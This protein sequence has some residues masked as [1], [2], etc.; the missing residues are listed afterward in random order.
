VD[1]PQSG[2]EFAQ[3]SPKFKPVPTRHLAAEQV[4]AFR[5]NAFA[6]YYAAPGYRVMMRDRFGPEVVREIEDM[7]SVNLRGKV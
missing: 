7:L 6:E 5:D 3:M 2:L 1:L 4:L